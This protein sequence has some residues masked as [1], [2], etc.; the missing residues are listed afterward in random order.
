MQKG[1]VQGR[2]TP[3]ELLDLVQPHIESFDYFLDEGVKR[4]V[5]NVDPIEVP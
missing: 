4:V 5:E 1:T 2:D 3:Q